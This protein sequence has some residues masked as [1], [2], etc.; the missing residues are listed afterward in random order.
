MGPTS[1]LSFEIYLQN[2]KKLPRRS[3]EPFK[4]GEDCLKKSDA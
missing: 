1:L 3:H 2:W 4:N